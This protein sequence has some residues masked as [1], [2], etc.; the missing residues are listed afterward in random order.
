MDPWSKGDYS[1]VIREASMVVEKLP[2]INP[3]SGRVPGQGLLAAPILKSRW[4]RNIGEIAK[5]CYV[6]EGFM[7]RGNIG[8]GGQQEVD[9]GVQAAPQHGQGWGRTTRPSGGGGLAP[10]R[11]SER[12]R[13]A[14]FLYF[15][16]GI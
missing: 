11:A 6:L 2:E 14:D 12:F 16:L 10:L 13:H 7:T 3:P 5:K 15:F 8:E 9:Q 4:R 1:R